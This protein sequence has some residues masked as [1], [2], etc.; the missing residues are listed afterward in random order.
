MKGGGGV[1]DKVVS[2]GSGRRPRVGWNPT[3]YRFETN[4]ICRVVLSYLHVTILPRFLVATP[5]MRLGGDMGPNMD[6]TINKIACA[7]DGRKM[8]SASNKYS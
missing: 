8:N 3:T 7:T 6:T 2:V 5:K 4:A 1:V